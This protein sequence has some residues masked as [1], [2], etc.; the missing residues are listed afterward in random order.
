TASP[1][2]SPASRR[3][4]SS[5][6][7][8]GLNGGGSDR[9]RRLR[10]LPT[11]PRGR[12]LRAMPG[13][14]APPHTNRHP[15][16]HGHGHGGDVDWEEYADQ[17]ER[18]GE[19]SVGVVRGAVAWLR[20]RLPA[21]VTRVLDVGSGPGVASAV[22]AEAFPEAEVVAVDGTAHLLERA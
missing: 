8:P 5:G 18:Q 12:R 13:H 6:S 21:T 7:E 3:A 2:T 10:D 11:G 9:C 4:P 17:L 16:G 20:P 14:H 1:S 15:H 22:L 19:V